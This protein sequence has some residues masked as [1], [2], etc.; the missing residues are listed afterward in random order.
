[1]I[2]SIRLDNKKWLTMNV[3]SHRFMW[4]FFTLHEQQELLSW[5]NICYHSVE[6]LKKSK[7]MIIYILLWLPQQAKRHKP[8]LV[9]IT[10][11]KP[12]VQT[13]SWCGCWLP[14]AGE[15]LISTMAPSRP[16]AIGAL[17][18]EDKKDDCFQQCLL[19]NELCDDC[20]YHQQFTCLVIPNP[21]T[22]QP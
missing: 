20:K 9:S 2:L 10:G 1:M 16:K 21:C 3:R 15:V 18:S 19:Q 13:L 7:A 22:K 4:I 12:L 11:W 14:F 8:L 17:G 5:F 6:Y